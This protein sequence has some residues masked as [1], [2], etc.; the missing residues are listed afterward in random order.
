MT[1]I[2]G[3]RCIDGVVLV[4][5]RKINSLE[6]SEPVYGDKITGEIR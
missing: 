4:A 5:D 2:M 1:L 3:A 6:E